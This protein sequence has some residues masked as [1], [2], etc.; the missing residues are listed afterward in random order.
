MGI[1]FHFTQYSWLDL[2]TVILTHV[3]FFVKIM[4]ILVIMIENHGHICLTISS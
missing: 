3:R 1:N 2:N 4:M